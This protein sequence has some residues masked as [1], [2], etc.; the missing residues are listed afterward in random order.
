ML[1]TPC[2]KK[3]LKTNDYELTERGHFVSRTG[4]VSRTGPRLYCICKAKVWDFL[5]WL[6]THNLLYFDMP[7]HR[8]ILDQYPED[9][10]IPRIENNIVEDNT[11]HATQ[12]L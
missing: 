10:T 4:A 1:C 6:T 9:D 12:I 5:L 7:L 3:I 8:T 2:L 11:S